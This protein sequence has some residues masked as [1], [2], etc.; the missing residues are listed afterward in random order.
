MDVAA[1]CADDARHA[2]RASDSQ[3]G[4]AVRVDPI[5]EHQV[6]FEGAHSR[7]Q[8]PAADEAVQTSRQHGHRRKIECLHIQAFNFVVGADLA[9]NEAA[10]FHAGQARVAHILKKH[11]HVGELGKT[12]H[13]LIREAPPGQIVRYRQHRCHHGNSQ[14]LRAHRGRRAAPHRAL[15]P[16]GCKFGKARF[17]VDGNR[18]RHAVGHKP[19]GIRIVFVDLL[20]SGRPIA[21]NPRELRPCVTVVTLARGHRQR[22]WR[23]GSTTSLTGVRQT[24]RLPARWGAPECPRPWR[25]QRHRVRRRHLHQPGILRRARPHQ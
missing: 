15:S 5:G 19:N 18:L 7:P 25:R 16:R 20:L 10:R 12:A 23:V 3:R 22:R 9:M 13:R 14:S 4:I 21:P 2:Q 6:G 1:Q 8:C 17:K 24:I 11:P